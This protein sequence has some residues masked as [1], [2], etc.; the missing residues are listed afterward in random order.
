MLKIKKIL[1][2]LLV[3]SLVLVI[4]SCGGSEDT[5]CK[6]CVDDNGDAICDVCEKEIPAEVNDVSL[7]IGGKP[8]FQVVLANG[9]SDEVK[10]T[11]TDAIQTLLKTN[12]DVDVNVVTENSEEDTKGDVEILVGE[13]SSRGDRYFTKSHSLGKKGFVINI[14]GSKIVINAG[15]D[16]MLIEAINIFSET[17]LTTDSIT[18]LKMKTDDVIISLPKYKVTDIKVNGTSIKDYTISADLTRKYH[19]NAALTLRD[20]IYSESGYWLEIVAPD[21]ATEKSIILKHTDTLPAEESFRVSAKDTQLFIECGYDNMFETSTA[22]FAT[23]KISTAKGEVNFTNTVYKQ[24]ISVVYYEDFGAVGDGRT[25]DFFAIYNAHVFA[26]ESGQT[27]KASRKPAGK[28]YYIY[29]TRPNP[30]ESNLTTSIPIKTTTD[31]QG[32]KFIIDDSKIPTFQVLSQ[33]DPT[34]LEPDYNAESHE[35]H[36]QLGTTSIFDILP[37]D[38]HEGFVFNDKDVLNSIVADGLN[39]NTTHINLKIDGWNGG[40]MIV[41]YNSAHK[42]FRR[43]GSYARFQSRGEDMHELIIID[44][45]GNVSE[46]TPIMFEYTNIDYMFVYKLD[47]N[48]AITVGNATIETVEPRVKNERYD[49]VTGKNLFSTAYVSRGIYVKRSYTTVHDIEHVLSGG[50]TPKER[51]NGLEGSDYQ[52]MFRA[53]NADHVKFKNCIMP[54]RKA[55]DGHSSY[56]FNANCVNKIVLENCI[57]PNFW[58]TIDP[59]EGIMYP[60]TEYTP[61]AYPSMSTVDIYDDTGK[62]QPIYLCWGIGGTN[63]CKNMEYIGSQLSRFDAHQGLYNGKI[64]DSTINAM[65]LT[66]Y[67]DVVLDNVD[68]YQYKATQT[69]LALRSDYGY[70]WNGNL[71]VKNTRAHLYDVTSVTPSLSIIG[72]QYTNFYF[73]YPTSFPNVTIDNLDVYST[74]LLAPVQSG[75]EIHL[76]Q[77]KNNAMMMH[78]SGNSQASVLLTY[79]DADG[80]D[81]IDE[82][83]FDINFDGKIDAL[84]KVDLDGNG[85][86][87]N[88]NLRY[89]SYAGVDEKELN[90]GISY[91]DC[92]ANVN[93]VRPPEFIKIINNDGVNGSGGY[94]YNVVNT[95]SD[96]ISDGGWHR[97]AEA[98][99]TF[100]GFFGNTKFIY[101]EGEGEYFHGTNHPEQTKTKTFKFRSFY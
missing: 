92:H 54:G 38:E 6:A 56:N 51:A 101:G 10:Q 70:L 66:G 23:M 28:V 50:F 22:Q 100:G 60:S 55:Y 53:A 63:Y 87:G 35:M 82:P 86:I 15:S 71:T 3:L 64:I 46:E 5:D 30:E 11:V 45:D 21:S 84:D 77:M 4:A 62:P 44:A 78:V 48:T 97:D 99:D 93:V 75:Y 74:K 19:E 90:K 57:Q 52:G 2:S 29:D 26:N 98:P 94:V 85:R 80:D 34:I 65:E 69:L 49:L 58:V 32:V 73:G 25:D 8:N 42:V 76:Y 89:S 72:H 33:S 27:V 81:F 9:S 17:V 67:G 16:E 40:L 14:I 20:S 13:V 41:P 31:W 47:P 12:H 36:Y 43:R 24:D 88:T 79:L 37:N 83:L 1:F 61:G 91:S 95:G 59:D 7:F 68:W 18:D 96:K 39:P